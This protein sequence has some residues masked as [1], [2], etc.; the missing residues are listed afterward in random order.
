MEK[1][2]EFIYG[3]QYYR[4]PTPESQNWES[5]LK[6]MKEMGFSHVKFW[7]QWRWTH[8]DENEFY[9]E[10]T[11]RLMDLAYQNGLKVTLNVI[12]DVAPKWILDRWP[13]SVMVMANGKEVE[14]KVCCYRQIGGFPGTC[15]NHSRAYEERMKFLAKTVERYATHPAMH[16]WDVW[17]EPEQ[18][19]PYR[20][21][22]KETLTCFCSSCQ[23]KFKGFLKKKYLTVQNLNTKWGRCYRDF[24]DIEMPKEPVTFADFIDFRE[25]QLDTMTGEANSRLKTVRENDKDHAAYLHVVPNTSSIFNAL[26]G[27]DDFELAKNCDVFASTNFAQPIWSIL[28]LSAGKGKTCYNMECHVGAGTTKMHQKQ[29]TPKMLQKELLPQIGMGIRGFMFWQYRPEILGL[30]APAWGVRKL[31]GSM[32]SVGAAAQDFIEKLSPYIQEI[33]ESKPCQPE[34]AIWK[35]RKNEI[36][37]FCIQENLQGFSKSIEAYV[38]AAYDHN[39]NCSIVDDNGIKDG[40]DGIRLLIMPYCYE[41]DEELIQA[42]DQFVKK[43]GM[44]LCEAHLG[45]YN[46]DTGR[47]SYHMPGMGVHEMWGLEEEYTT[48]SY[49]LKNLAETEQLDTDQFHGD[50]KKA[51]QAYGISGGKYFVIDTAFGFSVTG[52]E[53]FACLKAEDALNVGHFNGIPCM[54]LKE[55]GKGKILYCGTNIGEGAEADKEGF[56]KLFLHT[57]KLAGVSPNTA[58]TQ[59]G[60]HV[61]VLSENIVIAHNNTDH[62]AE[63]NLND[64]YHGVFQGRSTAD[65][66]VILEAES[67]E[68]FV[69]TGEKTERLSLV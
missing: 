58:D 53:R 50:M 7:V 48:S 27:V 62:I 65:G 47:H 45:G 68:L 38:N 33:M 49:H 36:F 32:G 5:D 20:E 69:K 22:N 30:E 21:P 37:S 66:K 54:V 42:V 44:L 15:Y 19:S 31:D 61:D 17:N 26:T 4:A 56:E 18:C 23:Q 13:D 6:N 67:A 60:I 9:F 3:T 41:A 28:T 34:I 64:T 25:F 16:M 10:D 39:F 2:D 14:P 1:W 12:F 46:A 57:A 43:G 35:G 29:V 40:L 11:D 55:H 8:R 51:L 24:D 59:S 52:A 63:L